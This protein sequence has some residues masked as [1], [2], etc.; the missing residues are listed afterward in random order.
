MYTLIKDIMD[1]KPNRLGIV[2]IL[3][4]PEK[5]GV[6]CKKGWSGIGDRAELEG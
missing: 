4:I 5:G 6:N 2:C 3:L 1:S